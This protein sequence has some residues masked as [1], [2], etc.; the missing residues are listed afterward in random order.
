[1][2][3]KQAMPIQFPVLRKEDF[4]S[5]S[6]LA[7]V[8]QHFAQ[9]ATFLNALTGVA[10]PTTLPSGVDVQGA[11][12]TGIGAPSGPTDAI[13]FGHAQSQYSSSAQAPNL[14][15]GG[16]NTLKGLAYTYQQ[17]QA[18][19]PAIAA[20]QAQLAGGVSGTITLAALTVGGTSGSI[21][22]TNGVITAFVNPT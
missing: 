15:I 16:K 13:S 5:D 6:G 2:M 4:S 14:D 1:M 18:N 22:V 19:G 11:T 8:N 20:I 17:V 21:T 9:I 12:V 7:V 3:A 10:G